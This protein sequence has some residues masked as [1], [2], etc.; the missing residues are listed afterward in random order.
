MFRLYLTLGFIL[1]NIY[2]F[3]RIKHHFINKGYKIWYTAIYMLIAGIYLFSARSGDDNFLLQ[4]LHTISDYL[5]PF[6]LYLF[7]FLLLFDLLVL[8]NLL[9]KI[10]PREVRMRFQF[11]VYTLSAII[12]LSAAVVLYG[13]INLN[14]IR[15]S[16]YRIDAP[17]KDSKIDH[18]KVAFVADFHIQQ[19]I[20]EDFVEQFVRK[21]NAI[22]PDLLL[23]GGDIIEGGN[24]ENSKLE[25]IEMILR[26]IHT[27][28][29]IYGVLGNHESYG[30][31]ETGNFFR[32]SG[33]VL[34][35]DSIAKIDSSFYL[36]GRYDQQ[37]RGR[38]EV[39]ELISHANN[40]PI[41]LLD[42]RPTELQETSLS[43]VNVQFSGHTHDGQLFP[44]NLILRS[45]Y[46]LTWGYMKIKNTHFFVTSGLRLW[47]PPVK[48]AGKS[49]IMVV[50][51]NFK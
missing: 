46:D 35:K 11:K 31:R 48:T 41:L 25:A 2:V 24:R 29:G 1:P 6:Y 42:H 23:Y 45:M 3:F 9:A 30:R 37:F 47:G 40:L 10:V 22:Q 13:A 21:I 20:P 5:L 38:K 34:L 7:L 28:Y 19:N 4:T 32:K 43:P 14:H 49:E 8:I 16:D 33:I 36:A 44:I 18:L 51:I 27:K 17:K 39:S 15:V 26:N 50:D 12:M